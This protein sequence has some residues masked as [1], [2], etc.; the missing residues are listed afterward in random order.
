MYK[1][2][3]RVRPRVCP[4]PV[5]RQEVQAGAVTHLVRRVRRRHRREVGRRRVKPPPNDETGGR[6]DK[7]QAAY[8]AM[9]AHEDQLLARL[10]PGLLSIP[11]L[12]LQGAPNLQHRVAT[13][14]FTHERHPASAIARQLSAAGV[15][16]HWGDNYAFEVARA[17]ELDPEEGVLR[18][19]LA[20]YNTI[21]EVD[22]ALAIIQSTLAV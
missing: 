11:G 7:F 1:L 6:R 14:S 12:S 2:P 13:V 8:G 3:L 4:V 20:H 10:L 17:L 19:G 18:L 16:C 22:E 15:Y 21:E 5:L 9:G